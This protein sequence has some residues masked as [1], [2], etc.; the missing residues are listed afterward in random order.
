MFP[1][2]FQTFGADPA[3]AAM[4][5]R[6]TTAFENGKALTGADA[7]FYQP[8][9]LESSLMDASMEA[10][11]AHLETL[12]RQ[13]IPY[14]PG[15]EAQLYHATV[16]HWRV[17]RSWVADWRQGVSFSLASAALRASPMH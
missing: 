15:Y 8:E 4:Y 6:L 14:A 11:A 1:S 3:N 9:L 2:I 17:K 12:A 10:R 16:I 5:S 7:A 13:G